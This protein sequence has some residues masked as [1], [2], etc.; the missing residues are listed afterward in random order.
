MIIIELT[1]AVLGWLQRD[2]SLNKILTNTDNGQRKGHLVN[3]DK[4]KLKHKF[5]AVCT[6]LLINDLCAL[7]ISDL[8]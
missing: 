7:R 4:H 5:E 1:A 8:K 3:V 6:Y 2:N